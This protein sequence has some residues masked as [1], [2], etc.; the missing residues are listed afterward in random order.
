MQLKINSLNT[1]TN[2]FDMQK[3]TILPV[4]SVERF[5]SHKKTLIAFI[6]DYIYQ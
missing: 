4:K 3:K 1:L 6:P 2:G 5:G